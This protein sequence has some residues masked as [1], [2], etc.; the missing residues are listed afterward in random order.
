MISTILRNLISNSIKFTHRNGKI[1]VSSSKKNDN[2]FITVKIS[3]TGV[4]MDK[5][6]INDLFH[7]DKNMRRKGTENE[8][9]TGLGLILCK[10]FVEKHKGYIDVES[11][12]GK[13][14]SFIFTIP[15]A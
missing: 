13:D 2:G 14:S 6:Q 10:E 15:R 11:T 3:D 5:N 9:G 1:T 12:V 8:T 4:G 7:I